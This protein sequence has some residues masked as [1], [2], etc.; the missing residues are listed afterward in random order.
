MDKPCFLNALTEQDA[1]FLWRITAIGLGVAAAQAVQELKGLRLPGVEGFAFPS[2]SEDG[3]ALSPELKIKIETSDIM[4]I[5]VGNKEVLPALSALAEITSELGVASLALVSLSGGEQDDSLAKLKLHYPGLAL[6]DA[7]I[8][9]W[10]TQP[11][12]IDNAD[13]VAH[14]SSGSKLQEVLCDLV[15]IIT[16]R[17]CLSIDYA[18][19]RNLLRFRG[20][21]SYGMGFAEGVSAPVNALDAALEDMQVQPDTHLECQGVLLYIRAWQDLKMSR[22]EAILTRCAERVDRDAAIVVGLSMIKSM[23]GQVA[24]SLLATGMPS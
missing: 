22:Y 19:I 16:L 13:T 15:E 18:D 2:I 20:N 24:C 21:C 6:L 11:A 5:A 17:D 7:L 14:P 8:P 4:V 9:V 23:Q 1:P 10:A 3:F 12:Y